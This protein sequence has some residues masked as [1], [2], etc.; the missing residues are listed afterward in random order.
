MTGTQ[1][2]YNIP[3]ISFWSLFRFII[4]RSS[5]ALSKHSKRLYTDVCSP[6]SGKVPPLW[7]SALWLQIA[8]ASLN[9]DL[10]LFNSWGQW[11]LFLLPLL[12]QGL[13]KCLQAECWAMIRLISLVFLLLGITI[14]CYL[15]SSIWKQL[16]NLS[17][18]LFKLFTMKGE[19]WIC[20]TS[21][22]EV[23]VLIS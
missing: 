5:W 22:P 19:V 13:E 1:S 14:L 23:E 4:P 11:A 8:P 17:C 18:P 10:S 16:S 15:L 7:N 6:S 9:S 3:L 12:C 2:G 21:W 20:F